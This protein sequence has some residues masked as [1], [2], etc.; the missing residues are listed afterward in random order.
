M[1][2]GGPRANLVLVADGKRTVVPALDPVLAAAYAR[3]ARESGKYQSV[4]VEQVVRE[5][6]SDDDH[7][8][9]AWTGGSK[10]S[11]GHPTP[12]GGGGL[13]PKPTGDDAIY[14]SVAQ[15]QAVATALEQLRPLKDHEEAIVVGP[16][17]A[18]LHHGHGTERQV[19]FTDAEVATF[20]EA[21]HAH[22]VHN[23]PSGT[24]FSG[25]DMSMAINSD[26]A[27]IHAIGTTGAG[28][29]WY[30]VLHRPE[31][32]WPPWAAVMASYINDSQ[33][34]RE[35]FTAQINAAHAAASKAPEGKQRD[36]LWAEFKKAIAR[37]EREHNHSVW[38]MVAKERGIGYRRRTW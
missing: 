3:V 18:L 31:G 21:G 33:T 4:E 28:E 15:K 1:L 12:K 19:Q 7:F 27:A 2:D 38:T 5:A 25:D 36:R 26:L 35:H 29:R 17:G 9:G 20:K 6:G 34:T 14:D 16:G 24:S 30:H 11:G 13:E 32:G 37:A 8:Y 22:L 23:H 10:A